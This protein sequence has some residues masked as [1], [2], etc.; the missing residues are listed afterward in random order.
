MLILEVS[1]A[2][3][4]VWTI[5]CPGKPLFGGESATFFPHSR[6]KV[7]TGLIDRGSLLLLLGTDD[8]TMPLKFTKEVVAMD[9][10]CTA[11][12][13]GQVLEGRGHSL[14]ICCGWEEVA[15]D[16]LGWLAGKGVEVR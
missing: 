13:A 7:D 6:A 1:N 11:V 3:Q 16:A 9:E 8:D 15:N 10:K 5:P 14:A 2:F 12:T 4:D